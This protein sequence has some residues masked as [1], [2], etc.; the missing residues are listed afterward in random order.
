MRVGCSGIPDHTPFEETV[1]DDDTIEVAIVEITATRN[2]RANQ[3]MQ[4]NRVAFSSD[5]L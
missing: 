5:G 2:K 1:F 3:S 4:L